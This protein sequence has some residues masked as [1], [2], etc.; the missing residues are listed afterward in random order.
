MGLVSCQAHTI[1]YNTDTTIPDKMID[2]L[3]E[4]IA[5]KLG[6]LSSRSP[7]NLRRR[8]FR[9]GLWLIFLASFSWFLLF[10]FV[11]NIL[12]FKT[13]NFIAVP[14]II[15]VAFGGISLILLS[16]FV[17]DNSNLPASDGNK[18]K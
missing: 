14:L 9:T 4:I 18:K 6:E 8:L 7:R 10:Y 1:Y 12:Q 16:R 2:I 5:L 13:V 3:I 17:P 11:N 15:I